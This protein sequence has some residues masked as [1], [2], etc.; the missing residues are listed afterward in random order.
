MPEHA[1]MI[2]EEDFRY[3][4][5]KSELH[6]CKNWQTLNFVL[7]SIALFGKFGQSLGS[8]LG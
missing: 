4:V 2:L 5:K 8:L 6:N 3:L 7:Q 1:H